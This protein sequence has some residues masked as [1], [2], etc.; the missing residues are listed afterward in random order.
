VTATRSAD[1][2]AW[3]AAWSEALDA[4]ELSLEETE[5]LL[6]GD[7]P[8]PGTP[9]PAVEPWTP[10]VLEGPMP[11]DLRTRALELH[12]RQQRVIRAAAEAAASLRKQAALTSKLSA[13]RSDATPVYLD[14]TA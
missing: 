4:L 7:V 5:R 1:E 12:H 6:R 11:V 13:G 14:V 10:P 3:H 9:A 2:A 8:D